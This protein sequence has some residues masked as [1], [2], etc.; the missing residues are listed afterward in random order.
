M[1]L[2]MISTTFPIVYLLNVPARIC[3]TDKVKVPHKAK[4]SKKVDVTNR[5]TIK[6]NVSNKDNYWDVLGKN[7]DGDDDDDDGDDDEDDEDESL[8][9]EDESLSSLDMSKTVLRKNQKKKKKIGVATKQQRISRSAVMTMTIIM[10]IN[11]HHLVTHP[12]NTKA[13][14][15]LVTHPRRMYY[16]RNRIRGRE[17]YQQN[18]IRRRELYQ[19]RM[20]VNRHMYSGLLE[21]I[22]L[23]I[24]LK[25][26]RSKLKLPI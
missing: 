14:H 17:L 8:S 10:M 22:L 13:S 12:L 19:P 25:K 4:G 3:N 20:H 18:R 11:H 15:C 6:V 2:Q 23:D 1:Y 24:M 5:N 21:P 7:R 9:N 26:M 16:Q